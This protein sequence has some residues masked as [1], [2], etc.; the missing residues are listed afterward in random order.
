MRAN[1]VT[2]TQWRLWVEI[3]SAGG[4]LSY[5]DAARKAMRCVNVT[6]TE[7][8][9]LRTHAHYMRQRGMGVEVIR[10]YGLRLAG[11]TWCADCECVVAAGAHDCETKDALIALAT[12]WAPR[13]VLPA[14]ERTAAGRF[15]ELLA[16]HRR[17]IEV[18][19]RFA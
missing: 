4:A 15:D 14:F 19:R 16:L 2:P 5:D 3:Q 10:G 1:V 12:R 18:R 6:G 13:P 7:S 8:N 17:E 11:V 9:A